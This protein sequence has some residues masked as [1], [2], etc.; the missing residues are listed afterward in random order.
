MGEQNA[1]RFRNWLITINYASTE[2][3]KDEFLIKSIMAFHDVRY[4]IFQLEEGEKKTLQHHILCCFENANSFKRILEGFPRANIEPV[5]N[6]LQKVIEYCS[7]GK[8]RISGSVK[9]GT[10]PQQGQRTDLEEIYEM[11]KDDAS[12]SQ[13]REKYPSAYLRYRLNIKSIRQEIVEENFANAVR[14]LEVTYI[15]GDPGTGKTRYVLEKHGFE[16][17]YRITD[18]THPFDQYQG[19]DVIVF[20]EFRSSLKIDDMLHYLDIYPFRLPARYE[21]RVAC[22]TKVYII[23]NIGLDEQYKKIQQE[24][25]LTYKAFLRRTNK[26]VMHFKDNKESKKVDVISYNSLR[27]FF[28]NQKKT[29]FFTE[30]R[31]NLSKSLKRLER[32]WFD[33]DMSDAEFKDFYSD[34][35]LSHNIIHIGIEEL[36]K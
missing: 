1:Q 20:E 15:F 6:S 8:G 32:D 23:T 36:L 12:D 14:N 9:Y 27:D 34:S 35:S 3:Y 11:I 13:I 4:F 26:G 7:K 33:E 22:Y 10:P 25:E 17:V 18:Y 30:G 28:K 29:R 31:F 2:I 19:E 21:N 5:T 24:Q 16:N